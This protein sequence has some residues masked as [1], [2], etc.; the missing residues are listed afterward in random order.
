MSAA[1]HNIIMMV[2]EKDL[3]NILVT[4]TPVIRQDV[5]INRL[6]YFVTLG[7]CCFLF[8]LDRGAKI[9]EATVCA[10]FCDIVQY[11]CLY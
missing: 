8:I 7:N 11:W 3:S 2:C 10:A 5:G 6:L 9:N 4:V 1:W